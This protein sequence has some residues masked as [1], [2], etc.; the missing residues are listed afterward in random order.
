MG[1]NMTNKSLVRE[2]Q[3]TGDTECQLTANIAALTTIRN[4]NIARQTQASSIASALVDLKW[5]NRRDL[6]PLLVKEESYGLVLATIARMHPAQEV[7][8]IELLEKHYQRIKAKEAETL[9][10]TR[11]LADHNWQGPQL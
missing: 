9:T 1:D 4:A 8:I 10:I 7:R 11:S 3:D 2:T 5:M 6:H